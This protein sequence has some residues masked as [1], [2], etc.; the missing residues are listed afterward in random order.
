MKGTRAG[1]AFD[2]Q[3]NNFWRLP[4]RT[5]LV[6]CQV[7]VHH[8][9]IYLLHFFQQREPDALDDSSFDLPFGRCRIN[10]ETD[11]VRSRDP[12]DY[13][14]APFWIDL[15]FGNMRSKAGIFHLMARESLLSHELGLSGRPHGLSVR[16]LL[17]G[18]RL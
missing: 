2:Q 7:R 16:D 15:D 18:I 11:V 9:A 14:I 3:G 17:G 10:G 4:C 8:L 1:C 5:K 12:L 13:H 6:V